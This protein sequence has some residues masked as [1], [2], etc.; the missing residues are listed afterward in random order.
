[1]KRAKVVMALAVAIHVA[2]FLL[3]LRE[4]EPFYSWFYSIAWWTYIFLLAAANHLKAQNS[5]IFDKPREAV[6][7]FLFSTTLWLFFEIF[8][9]RLDNWNYV[10]VPIQTYVRWPGYFIA[11]GTVLPGIFETETMVRNLGIARTRLKPVRI[12]QPLLVRFILL[13]TVMMVFPILAPT[14]FFPFVWLGL[15]F[16]LDPLLYWSA[17]A[18]HDS[19][20]AQAER[21]DYSLLLRL[22]IAGMIC[23]LLWEFWNFWAGS[24]WI[25][26]VPKLGFLKLFEMPFLGFFGFPPFALECYLAYRLSVLVRDR[27][28]NRSIVRPVLVLVLVLVYCALVFQGIDRYNVWTFSV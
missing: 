25:Y 11:F 21:G 13:G 6:W 27:Y 12:T 26:S 20:S 9:F 28:L 19:F 2:S 4:V 7:V 10:G 16:L 3:M 1:M 24:K 8:N 23:G 14:W 18:H 15:I 22:L 17:E 5:L